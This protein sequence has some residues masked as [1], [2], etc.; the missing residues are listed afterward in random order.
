MSVEG[1][2]YISELIPSS[3]GGGDLISEG[4]NQIRMVKSV[5]QNSF[6]VELDK[7]LIPT[8]VGQE[9]KVLTVNEDATEIVWATPNNTAGTMYFRYQASQTQTI[10]PADGF[11]K[12][13]YDVEKDD[14]NNVW[15]S[16]EWLITVPGLYYISANWRIITDAIVDHDIAVFINDSN[17][18]QYS[19]TDYRSDTNKLHTM[20]IDAVVS[21]AADD[22]ISIRGRSEAGITIGSPNNPLMLV[23]GYRIK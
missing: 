15:N 19:Y 16:S 23:T 14:V 10:E 22:K 2:T 7:P 4:D 20:Q 8:V 12:V 18:R 1:A 17:F 6:P 13:I 9:D 3:P 11:K 5:L 21:A